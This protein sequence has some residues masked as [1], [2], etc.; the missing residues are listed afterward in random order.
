MSLDF[1]QTLFLEGRLI[2]G[3]ARTLDVPPEARDFL[4]SALRT[5]L[6]HLPGPPLPGSLPTLVEAVQ[7]VYRLAWDLLN[8]ASE[9]SEHEPMSHGPR[10]ADDHVSADVA[11]RFL[12]RL[13]RQ[14][15]SRSADGPLTRLLE[16]ILRRWPLSGVL[17]D[18]AEAPLSP[19]DFGG[20]VGVAFL[21]AE[22][23]AERERSHW[24]P[25]GPAREGLD[26]VWQALGKPPLVS[27][28]PIPETEA[29]AS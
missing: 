17:A 18:I 16:Q 20:H 6:L 19:L 13:F 9:T 4:A 5:Q 12:P 21:Y 23:L 11:F 7:V 27:A 25:A 2:V 22:R 3:A 26:V 10:S 24:I 15:Q 1:I 8:G 28:L 14:A 29:D